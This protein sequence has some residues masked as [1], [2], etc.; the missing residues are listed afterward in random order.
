MEKKIYFF[1]YLFFILF[2][3]HGQVLWQLGTKDNSSGDFGDYGTGT[4]FSISEDWETIS[5]WTF[6]PKG[7]NR[8]IEPEVNIVYYLDNVPENGLLFRFK[9]LHAERSVP[10]MAVFSNQLMAG[11]IQ[12]FGTGNTQ[13]EYEWK[14]TYELYIPKEF[15]VEGENIL[16]LE[17]VQ[18]IYA[19]DE[20]RLLEYLY[21]EW[22]YLQ[23]E[24]LN[25]PIDDPVHGKATFLGTSFRKG[26][27]SFRIDDELVN[28]VPYALKWLGIAYSKNPLRAGFW[29]DVHEQQPQRMELIQAY[30]KHNMTVTAN[31]IGASHYNLEGGEI[32][33][34]T[35]DSLDVFIQR[36]GDYFQFYEV[37]NEPCLIGD[38]P[39]EEVLKLT[40]YLV[41]NVPEHI[42]ITAPGWAYWPTGGDP[43]GW[44]RD[45][46][47]RAEIE[48]V[49]QATNGHSYGKSYADNEGGSFI[50]NLRSYEGV[51]DGWIKP[52]VNT[53]TGTNDSHTDMLGFQ[54]QSH[55]SAFDRIIRA[56]VSVV[57]YTMQHSAFFGNYG[58]FNKPDW[59]D[60]VGSLRTWPG[61]N[62]QDPRLQTFRRLALT[63]AT[64][65]KP[66]PF[67]YI[68]K[69]ELNDK[70][71]YVRAVDTRTLEP[72]PAGTS[73]NKLILSFVNFENSQITVN[74]AF[75]M[76][77]AGEYMAERFGNEFTYAEA[78]S[79]TYLEAL[80]EMTL[81][82]EIPPRGA[83]HYILQDS[84]ISDYE[85][86]APFNLIPEN[87]PGIIEAENFD[88]GVSDSAFYDSDHRN[89][90]G[91]YR[92]GPV[93]IDKSA[94]INGGYKIVD[95]ENGEWL[96]Y[97]IDISQTDV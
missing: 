29:T 61:V 93:D 11:L 69:E 19:D 49:A 43:D 79:I 59:Q 30:D 7:L 56:H 37:E 95:T 90:G 3:I 68:N 26:E 6:F 1:V 20:D 45:P 54:T 42:K 40:Q 73:S 57:D 5:D 55:A 38:Q 12:L 72:T 28:I 16:R 70:K 35:K 86:R 44:C 8:S 82:V 39:K 96:E 58:L 63:Y 88:R 47:A 25:E 10:E 77:D 41:S 94:D 23:L 32:P 17:A 74:A 65:G 27:H 66:I 89:T 53:E 34:V 76:P 15:L 21:W 36:Y 75:V 9:L 50:E 52:F 84:S 67:S 80:P 13:A 2:S 78:H 83:V 71:I 31:H 85:E 22:D 91:H 62:G 97:T 60:P 87:I 33:Q 24:I 48:E 46:E 14:K 4:T 81:E 51:D 92:T 64:H 18:S